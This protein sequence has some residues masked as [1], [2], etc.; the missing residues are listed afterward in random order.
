MH[1]TSAGYL[2]SNICCYLQNFP[3]SLESSDS[4]LPDFLLGLYG[5]AS[6]I[7]AVAYFETPL[8]LRQWL[9]EA[10]AVFSEVLSDESRFIPNFVPGSS[11]WRLAQK[12]PLFSLSISSLRAK[13]KVKARGT[14]YCPEITSARVRKWSPAI[15]S[16]P[17]QLT[18]PWPLAGIWL[19]RSNSR[20]ND[21]VSDIV[22]KLHQYVYQNHP[23]W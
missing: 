2:P 18:L 6:V 15:A 10:S 7:L 4:L 17:E 23:N 14:E 20:S 11:L 21:G 1:Q 13:F 16:L 19:W 8:Y 9:P 5:S 12:W 22:P 3:K